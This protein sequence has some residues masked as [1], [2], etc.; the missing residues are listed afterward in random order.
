MQFLLDSIN[1]NLSLDIRKGQLRDVSPGAGRVFGLLSLQT[2]PRRLTLDFSDVFKK[3]L[4]F[5]RIKGSFLLERGDAY[6]TNLYLDG[7]AARIDISGRTGLAVKDYDQ[8]VTVT[9]HVTASL[10][11]AGALVGGPVAGGVLYA[12]DK[13]FKP[14]IEKI[15][16]YQYTITGSWDDPQIV[17]LTDSETPAVETE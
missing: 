3:G 15:T 13:L 6:T 11:L 12:I 4:T 8:L 7:P 17:K 10:P 16:Q 1:G 5:D 2:L 14:T 9:P